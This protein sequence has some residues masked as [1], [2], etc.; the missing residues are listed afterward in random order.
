M[1]RPTQRLLDEARETAEVLLENVG[2]HAAQ[3]HVQ[4]A[5]RA[6]EKDPT[7]FWSRVWEALHR[8]AIE[9]HKEAQR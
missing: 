3:R 9:M 4:A 6:E 7:Q 5:I 8:L 1:G 2:F